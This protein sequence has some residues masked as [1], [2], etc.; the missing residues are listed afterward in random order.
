MERGRAR[1]ATISVGSN[2][3]VSSDAGTL[4]RIIWDKPSGGTVRVENAD[5]GAAPDLNASGASTLFLGLAAT[6][7]FDIPFGPG[8]SFD[9]LVIA[10][11]SNAKVV[12][13]YE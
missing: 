8:I 6:T 9:K 5:L 7:D 12:A 2:T 1:I 10:A 3:T 11:S 4:Y 13:I